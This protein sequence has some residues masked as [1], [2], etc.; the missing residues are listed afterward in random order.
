MLNTMTTAIATTAPTQAHVERRCSCGLL[1]VL[2]VAKRCLACPRCH[3]AT[4][5][6]DAWAKVAAGSALPPLPE[7]H[8][9]VEALAYMESDDVG[10]GRPVQQCRLCL[11]IG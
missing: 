4:A 6:E 5:T 3:T 2:N 8:D 7:D 1:T 9:F 11:T 10:G